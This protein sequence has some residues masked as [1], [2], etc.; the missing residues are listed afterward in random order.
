MANNVTYTP[1]EQAVLLV[2]VATSGVF[3]I[4][5]ALTII[6]TYVLW[7]ETHSHLRQLL[8]WLSVCDLGTAIFHVMGLIIPPGEGI[9]CTLQSGFAA[10]SALSSYMWTMA[11]ALFL[12]LGLKFDSI[13]NP[14]VTQRIFV[15][16]HICCWGIPL[17]II[18]WAWA[19]SALGY[20]NRHKVGWCWVA[21][22]SAIKWPEYDRS[23]IFWHMMTGIGLELIAYA[24]SQYLYVAAKCE[25]NTSEK[26]YALSSNKTF[27]EAVS[28]TDKKL[29]MVPLIFI[30]ARIWGSVRTILVDFVGETSNLYWLAL[31]QGIGD[32]AQG[33]ANCITF[34]ILTKRW[35]MLFLAKCFGKEYTALNE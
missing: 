16:F 35:R 19:N 3:S 7:P 30:F 28:G 23:A 5:G 34:C 29:I 32:S 12:Y 15:G 6:V 20:D 8:V 11:V 14:R 25:L 31:A 9:T 1:I 24:V 10:F 21:P 4:V 22:S 13:K 26:F 27:K 17:A 18:A 2:A 33:W